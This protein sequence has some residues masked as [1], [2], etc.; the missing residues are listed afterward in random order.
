MISQIDITGNKYEIDENTRKYAEKHIGKLDK[1]L[2]RHA[3]KSASAKVVIEEI[4][5]AHDNKYEVEAILT[6]PDKTLVAKDQSSN[7]LAAIDIVQAKLDGQIR[8]YKTEKNPRLGKSGLM[9]R[10]KRSFKRG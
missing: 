9:A 2:P 10:F 4:N 1:Y 6:V 7:V 8:R 5:G 3:K